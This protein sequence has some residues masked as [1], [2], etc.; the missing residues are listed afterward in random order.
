MPSRNGI[1]RTVSQCAREE[2]R[3]R[4][5]ASA[6]VRT[7]RTNSAP[8]LKPSRASPDHTVPSPASTCE[9]ADAS[10]PRLGGNDDGRG[11]SHAGAIP[12]GVDDGLV[13]QRQPLGSPVGE[14]RPSVEVLGG[15]QEGADHLGLGV[16]IEG[17]D[18]IDEPRRRVLDQGEVPAEAVEHRCGR[19]GLQDEELDVVGERSDSFPSGRDDEYR[20]CAEPPRQL[21]PRQRTRPPP[22]PR[23]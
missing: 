15:V 12:H 9:A 6:A 19:L 14:E 3:R 1:T 21:R 10:A 13:L 5:A 23:R 4:V 2:R 17:A 11:A 8:P 16:G 20:R 22:H 18:G 7:H